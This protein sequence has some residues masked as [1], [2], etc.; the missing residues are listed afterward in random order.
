MA[1]NS[2]GSFGPAGPGFGSISD[3]PPGGSSSTGGG[4]LFGLGGSSL[5]PQGASALQQAYAGA[6]GGGLGNMVGVQLGP[7]PQAP[8]QPFTAAVPATFP[9]AP[10]HS[11]P[12]P[13]P[14]PPT[15]NFGQ[16]GT[17]PWATLQGAGATPQEMAGMMSQMQPTYPGTTM[18]NPNYASM[19]GRI[20]AGLGPG[21]GNNSST[22]PGDKVA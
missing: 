10:P 15:L 5:A 20:M 13:T 11:P 14:A 21:M 2:F 9:P 22:S 17:N 8:S 6:Q 7:L 16:P 1:L 3:L 12:V 19:M 4:G 18:V